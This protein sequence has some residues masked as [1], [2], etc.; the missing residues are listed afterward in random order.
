MLKL[1]L[2]LAL[3]LVFFP[4]CAA[5]MSLEEAKKVAVSMAEAPAFVP[6]PRRVDDIL[7]VLNQPGQFD[8][9]I[10]EKFRAQANEKPPETKDL[11]TLKAF[12][13]NRGEAAYQLGHYMKAREDFLAALNV[14]IEDRS[15]GS[16][17]GGLGLVEA[18]CGNFRKAIDLSRE[19]ST[20]RGYTSP[21]GYRFGLLVSSLQLVN[22]YALIGDL[23]SAKNARL[24]G[25]RWCNESRLDAENRFWCEMQLALM[26][27]AI[28][29]AQGKYSE[30]GEQHR[31]IKGLG[32]GPARVLLEIHPR[33]L[34][35]SDMLYAQNLLNQKRL[36]EAE[37]ETRQVLSACLAHTGKESE[38][39]GQ[40][41][42]L[43]SR[44]LLSQ[45]RM[46]EAEGMADAAVRILESS[47][48][49]ADSNFMGQ[50]RV[51]KGDVLALKEDYAGALLQYDL[52][53]DSMRENRFLY[54][55]YLALSPRMILSMLMAGR[56]EEAGAVA[57]KNYEDLRNRLNER[58][59]SAAE[60]LALR[61]MSHARSDRLRE[62]IRDLS[63]STEILLE[64]QTEAGEFS[65]NR[66]TRRIILEDY[67]RLL[68]R[69]QGST[70]ERELGIDV[71]ET[72]FKLAEANRGKSVQGA[73]VASGARSA[74]TE[75]ALA[76]LIRQ[77]QDAGNQISV[78][79]NTIL[80]LLAA[81]A[82]QRDPNLVGTLQKNVEQLRRAR[83][84]LLKETK[85]R[86]P[87]YADFVHPPLQSMRS[88]QGILCPGEVLLS[89]YA[90][91]E[92]T[93][94]WAVPHKGLPRFAAI[95]SGGKSLAP[96]A[97]RLRQSLDAKPETLGDIPDFDVALAHDLYVKLFSP[98]GSVLKD[99]TD[100]II[101]ANSPLD[102]IPFAVL[103]T[104]PF[105]LA[106]ERG[107][108]FARYRQAPWL[109]R[110]V[111]V[112]M[113]PSVSALVN[114]RSLPPYDPDRKAFLG[115]GDPLFN[116]EQQASLTLGQD[117]ESGNSVAAESLHENMKEGRIQVRGVRITAKGNLDDRKIASAQT[118][119]LNRLPDTAEE[120]ESIGRELNADVE[121]D[122]FLRERASKKRVRSMTLSD[123]KVVAFATHALIPGDLDGLDQPALALSSPSVTGD[124]EDGLLTMTDIMKLKLNA[125]WVVLSACNTGAASGAGAEVLSGLGQAFF[126][127][128]SR[129]I[130]ASLYPVETISARKLVT[131]IFQSQKE[132]KTLSRTQA[133][134]KSMLNLMDK[135]VLKDGATG[136]I[137]AAY[138]HPLFWAP[139]VMVGDPGSPTGNS[140]N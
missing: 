44:I 27:A 49:P 137:V 9:R 65:A 35:Y 120:I 18:Y 84:A 98:V 79:E 115:F 96:V 86:F 136:R 87:K 116:R 60:M 109:I 17:K 139:F 130:L 69:I 56:H 15:D 7:S 76:D 13:R 83:G 30:A 91:G 124:R 119:N 122:V 94:V 29:R 73:L 55:K 22:L 110:K 4:G 31:K 140:S 48:V 34:I 66:K 19:S 50:A 108:L 102:S 95:P 1:L 123:R 81:P 105:Q 125:D 8:F 42:L 135:E 3:L 138:A 6:P 72:A 128:G 64:N 118:E 14:G 78:M 23:D 113:E 67:I 38:L 12:Y 52:A 88:V 20:Y 92:Q 89:F 2:P 103:P 25:E 112:T 41:I 24:M 37:V 45:G 77:E 5:R 131:G 51:T 70:L 74:V 57:S 59:E 127:A 62:A 21:S 126:Y 100:L 107:E 63:A 47:G 85:R 53:R 117:R 111:S 114:L 80:D 101:I 132:D 43:L 28:F 16:I 75:P 104:A 82:S 58:H 99:A 133:L 61:G 39:S 36:V 106:V 26:D 90:A 54:D 46:E 11:G 68:A 121:N 40:A 97:A 134:R 10:T 71:A 129:A 93:F 32:F 33:F